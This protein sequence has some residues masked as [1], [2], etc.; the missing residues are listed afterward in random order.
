[1]AAWTRGT[2]CAFSQAGESGYLLNR[3]ASGV[4]AHLPGLRH[5]QFRS[6]HLA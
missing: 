1:M 6:K 2:D 4:A 3:L 5:A